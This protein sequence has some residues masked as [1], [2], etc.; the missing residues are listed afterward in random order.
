LQRTKK[1]TSPIVS[2]L[3][4]EKVQYEATSAR[5]IFRHSATYITL[6][7]EGSNLG[8]KKR[9]NKV[10][11]LLGEGDTYACRWCVCA[12]EVDWVSG[13]L[14]IVGSIAISF[15]ILFI[16]EK[17]YLAVC[18]ATD[19]NSSHGLASGWC[20]IP[21]RCDL[22]LP[23]KYCT[24]RDGGTLVALAPYGVSAQKIPSCRRKNEIS[25]RILLLTS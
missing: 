19:V 12:V 25:L 21:T 23:G 3:V 1:N 11:L 18:C 10:S 20:P 8:A 22:N 9:F 2:Q 15:I 7:S 5:R 24:W 6:T 13:P 16:I 17:L 14:K 4:R